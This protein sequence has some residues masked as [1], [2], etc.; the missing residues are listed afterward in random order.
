MALKTARRAAVAPFY[1]ME[2]LRAANRREAAGA[3]VLHLEVGE[4]AAGAPEPVRAAARRALEAGRIGYTE[5]LGLPRLRARIASHYEERHG[6]S[7]DPARV[8]VTTG[9]SGA[10]VLSF[11]A[12]FDAG[13]RV[14]LAE[15]GYPAYRNI[16]QSFGVEVVA[17]AADHAERFQPTPETLA[18]VA[19]L[20]GVIVAS[21]S[22]PTGSMLDA[23]ALAALA[24]WCGDNGV[25]LI[26]DEI[27]HGITY[28]V[29]ES[30]VLAHDAN[31]VAINSFSKYFAMTGWRLGWT[32]VPDDL[33]DAVERLAQ[34]LFISPPALPQ[35]AALEAFECRAALDGYVATYARNRQV[36]LDRLPEAGFGR[37][38]PADGAFYVYADIGDL[39][40]DSQALCESMLRDAAVAATPGIDFDPRRGHRFVRFSFA[41]ATADIAEAADRLVAVRGAGR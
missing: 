30:S 28:G 38:A 20:D 6:L 40:A 10:F 23:P 22:N 31:A 24:A 25:R 12:A 19:P 34:N 33:V 15:P 32:I 39:A 7:V 2:V 8:A 9:A 13:D 35:H 16:L 3:R 5:A 11:L 21:P 14:A 37:L 26:S 18:A 27:Y 36:L 41:G 17:L 4:P 1:A 29:R